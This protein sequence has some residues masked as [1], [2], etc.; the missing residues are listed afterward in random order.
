M[1]R[2]LQVKI[3]VNDPTAEAETTGGPLFWNDTGAASIV[4]TILDVTDLHSGDYT[5]RVLLEA[6]DGSKFERKVP[7]SGNPFTFEFSEHDLLHTGQFHGHLLLSDKSSQTINF[8]FDFEVKVPDG[9]TIE[10]PPKPVI[11]LDDLFDLIKAMSGWIKELQTNPKYKGPK[12]DSA[13]DLYKQVHPDATLADF[14][15]YI[16]GKSAYQVWLDNGNLGD[17]T[18]FLDSLTAFGLWQKYQK[19]PDAKLSDFFDYLSALGVWRRATNQPDGTAEQFL[20]SQ[21]AFGVW[22]AQT[23]Q[24]DAK[25]EDYLKAITGPKGAD[26]DGIRIKGKLDDVSK[27]PKDGLQG[28]TYNV[29]GELYSYDADTKAYIDGGGFK[30]VEATVTDDDLRKA[31]E[32]IADETVPTAPTITATAGNAQ[33]TYT[34]TPAATADKELISRYDVYYK[35]RT[36]N[37]SDQPAQQLTP[38]KLTGTITN[39]TNDTEYT[40]A[41][42]AINS[43]GESDLNADGAST[44]VTTKA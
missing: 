11:A 32:A 24:P 1:D 34:I 9:M 29:N 23:K 5:A 30:I 28:D 6:E 25:F 18:K 35:T 21:N 26:G 41:V 8:P 42:K 7:V 27:L 36:D 39:L 40:I 43:L 13:F 16:V 37:W 12:G 44:R 14:M 38:D 2:S 4:F 3:K 33:L 19:L 20:E 22:K 15:A 31:V 17:E 10:Q